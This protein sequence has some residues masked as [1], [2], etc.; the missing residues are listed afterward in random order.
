MSSL[1]KLTSNSL[2]SEVAG[3]PALPER[4][5]TKEGQQYSPAGTIWRFHDG[6]SEITLNYMLYRPYCTDVFMCSLR[7]FMVNLLRSRALDSCYG[8]FERFRSLVIYA[9]KRRGCML[10]DT[11]SA[12]DVTGYRSTLSRSREYIL[13]G[14]R[15]NIRK[16]VELGYTGVDPEASRVLDKLK[17][18]KNESGTAVLNHDP[19]K[20]PFN[21]EEFQAIAKYLLD[22][23]AIGAIALP[24]LALVFLFMAFG[25]RPVSYAALRLK[26]FMVIKDRHGIEQYVLKIPAAKRMHG[27]RRTHFTE[28]KLTR[29]YGQMLLALAC[30]VKSDFAEQLAAGLDPNELPFFP[31]DDPAV[32]YASSSKSIY[33]KVVACFASETTIHC[34]REGL[35]GTALRVYPKRFRNTVGTRMAEEGKRER[36]IAQALGHVSLASARVYV[37]ATGKIRHTINEKLEQEINPIAQYFLGKIVYSEADAIR[38]DDPSSRVR[39]FLGDVNG[40]TLGNCGKT[41]FCGGFVP[42]PCYECRNFQPWVDAPHEEVLAWLLLDRQKKFDATSDERYATVNDEI[43]K[44]VADVARR[45][46]GLRDKNGTREIEP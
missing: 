9:Y 25:P 45:C 7:L 44:K 21:D 22:R 1:S 2:P 3:A 31:G 33:R 27:G 11:V 40:A 14:L 6:G 19:V 16:W 8:F 42:L 46:I 4:S 37:E 28:R 13:H 24:E 5:Y 34:N 32:G 43:V 17:L 29:E 39:S 38:G 15:G 35:E 30:H 10:V 41:G 18:K 20:G 26:D 12:S 36:E 23:Y